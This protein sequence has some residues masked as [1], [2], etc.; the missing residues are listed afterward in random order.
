MNMDDQKH[1]DGIMD[2]TSTPEWKA[3][4]EE[5]EKLVY[6]VQADAL[7][8]NSWD[9][10]CEN[11]GFCRGLAFFINLRENTKKMAA[12]ENADI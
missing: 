7:E 6:N 1:Y 8:A 9:D 12:I 11:R 2:L 4:V 3:V 10:V 5:A